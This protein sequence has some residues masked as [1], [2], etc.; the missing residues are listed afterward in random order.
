MGVAIQMRF[1]FDAVDDRTRPHIGSFCLLIEDRIKF[2]S[3]DESEELA[4]G[5]AVGYETQ[6]ASNLRRVRSST[7]SEDE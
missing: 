1:A 3:V 7:A 5:W 6:G 4:K 2:L